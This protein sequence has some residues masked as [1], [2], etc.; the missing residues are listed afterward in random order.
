[1][2]SAFPAFCAQAGTP[3]RSLCLSNTWH[4]A[5]C[6]VDPQDIC[7]RMS[8]RW[9]PRDSVSKGLG[10]W[11]PGHA[12]GSQDWQFCHLWRGRRGQAGGAAGGSRWVRTY[13][14]GGSGTVKDWCQ[15]QGRALALGA[16]QH[17][18][19]VWRGGHWELL[20][21]VAPQLPTRDPEP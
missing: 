17:E 6:R 14:V 11:H 8:E 16:V 20:N 15:K 2:G 4:T 12:V 21:T 3:G 7:E 18:G 5:R 10:V 19:A 13:E 9:G 1:M